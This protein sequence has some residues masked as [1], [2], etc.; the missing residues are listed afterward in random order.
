MSTRYNFHEYSPPSIGFS[1]HPRS[2][3]ISLQLN[4]IY[5]MNMDQAHW[6]GFFVNQAASSDQAFS[7]ATVQPNV[8]DLVR[9]Y[10]VDEVVLPMA[11]NTTGADATAIKTTIE[12]KINACHLNM[13]AVVGL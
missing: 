3:D 8:L 2:P 1:L 10:I 13:K 7:T 6:Q 11:T 4:N 9:T 5:G 12:G